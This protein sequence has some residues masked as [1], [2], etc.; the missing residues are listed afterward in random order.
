ML[1]VLLWC[2]AGDEN[3]VL[4][5]RDGVAIWH[6]GVDERPI[7]STWSPITF[8]FLGDQLCNGD[9]QLLEEGLMIPRSNIWSN[10]VLSG[11]VP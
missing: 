8:C 6:G 1:Q 9:D 10:S 4:Q 5:V 11:D 2:S 3:V 7:V